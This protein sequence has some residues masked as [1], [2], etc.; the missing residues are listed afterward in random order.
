MKLKLIYRKIIF[1]IVL[2]IA[3]WLVFLGVYQFIPF[4]KEDNIY[5]DYVNP[6]VSAMIIAGVTLKFFR[7]P[8]KED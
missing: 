1:F 4:A 8:W 3:V 7:I 5:S 2:S 6:L